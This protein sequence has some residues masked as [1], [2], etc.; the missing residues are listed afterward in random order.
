LSAAFRAIVILVICA[1]SLVLFGWQ[2]GSDADLGFA[3][4]NVLDSLERRQLM[5]WMLAVSTAVGVLGTAFVALTT[6]RG[7]AMIRSTAHVVAP[8][9]LIGFVPALMARGLWD[10][11]TT[12][13]AMGAFIVMLESLLRVSLREVSQLTGAVQTVPSA[14]G[15]GPRIAAFLVVLLCAAFYAAYM[16]RYTLYNHRRFGTFGFDLG[17]YNN[18]FW[19]TLHGYPFRDSPLGLVSNWQELG[20]HAELSVIFLL[21][22]YAIRPNAETLLIMQACI[23]GLGAIPIYLF[24]SRRLPNV[25]ACALAVSYLLYAPL[26]GSNFYDF[27]FQPIAATFVLFTIYFVDV[28]RWVWTSIFYVVAIGCRED[29]SIGLTVLGLFFALTGYRA[30]AGMVMAAVGTAYFVVMKFYVMPHFWSSWFAEIYKD[31]Y[32]KPSGP[33][34]FAGVIQTLITN[35]IHVFRTLLT[36]DKLRY[37]LQ[38]VT[39]LAFLPLRRAH[40]LPAIVPGAIFTLLTT[41]YQPTVDIGFQYSGHFTAYIFPAAALMLAAYRS[42]R[43]GYINLRAATVALVVGTL[44]CTIHWGAFPPRGTIKGGFVQVGFAHPSATDEQ[45]ARDLAE[46]EAMIPSAASLSVTEEEL[47]HMAGHLNV[48]TLRF[49]TNAADYLLYGVNSGGSGAANQALTMGE[50]VEVA[51]RPGLVLLKRKATIP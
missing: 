27:H 34:S 46:L 20:N 24:A 30:R 33:H 18:I 47:P 2:L 51:R 1:A 39:P 8:L 37:F 9:A 38:I 31:L 19:S 4:D 40:F 11:L 36:S 41:A 49:G 3:R 16:S 10:P 48:L 17:Q 26:H 44:L 22:F 29:I 12:V 21:P 23:L 14:R 25:Y 45:K 6:A 15:R 43:Q 50:Y 42:E 13:V 7:R 32:P 28:R 5:T 35:P